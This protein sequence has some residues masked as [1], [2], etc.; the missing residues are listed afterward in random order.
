MP[1]DQTTKSQEVDIAATDGLSLRAD[2]LSTGN[3]TPVLLAHG[4]GQT[5]QSWSATQGRLSLAGHPNLAWD[6]RGHGQSGRNARTQPY[7]VEQFVSDHA[8]V[9]AHL[10]PRPVLVGAS[11]GGL[12]GLL[13]Q[14]ATT[15]FS[16]LVLVD[17]TPRW[18]VV[19]M[20][21][22]YAFMSAF[23]QGFE[24]FAEAAQAIAEYLPQRRERKTPAQLAH[25]L[26]ASPDGRLRWHW[27]PRLLAEFVAHGEQ[28]QDPIAA[29]ASRI[30]V[31]V[32][33]ISG[34]RSDLVS[35]DTIA[36]FLDLVP[37]A[38]HV[39]L[40]TATHMLAGDDNDS[41]THTLLEFL[42]AQFPGSTCAPQ[43]LAAPGSP[44][45]QG[46]ASGV[47]R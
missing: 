19:G 36:H 14:A 26:K 32:L 28:L 46:T 30:E 47:S 24:S 27:D 2:L 45:L 10:G 21:R 35:R 23:P 9:A 3:R 1:Q 29:A 34:G 6:M 16:A 39:C 5:R 8:R 41:F 44:V 13:C 40:P 25:L 31:P 11:M 38:E 33:L 43:D 4:F 12:A 15:S 20:Q 42:R 37:H 22:I 18:E 7:N 17:V